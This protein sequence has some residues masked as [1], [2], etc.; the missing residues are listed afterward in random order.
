MNRRK[1]ALP[2]SLL[3]GGATASL[4]LVFCDGSYVFEQSMD[5]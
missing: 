1:A 4:I 3:K 5:L 2:P